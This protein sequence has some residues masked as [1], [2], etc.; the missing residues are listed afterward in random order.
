MNWRMLHPH[1]THRI[2]LCMPLYLRPLLFNFYLPSFVFLKTGNEESVEVKQKNRSTVKKELLMAKDEGN[3]NVTNTE[4]EY[5]KQNDEMETEQEGEN[6]LLN[7]NNKEMKK[8]TKEEKCSPERVMKTEKD[9]E[10]EKREGSAKKKTIN[11]F[12]GEHFLRSSHICLSAAF[13][14]W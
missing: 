10:E 14:A 9:A 1:Y 13:M 5:K 2:I 12:F 6:D 3:M 4:K 11:S 8:V 7:G